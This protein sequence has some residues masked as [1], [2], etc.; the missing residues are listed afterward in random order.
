MPEHQ[1]RY[2]TKKIEL[3][4]A[5]YYLITNEDSKI[6]LH[7]YDYKQENLSLHYKTRRFTRQVIQ[8][9]TFDASSS[10]MQPT[11]ALI[12]T[13]KTGNRIV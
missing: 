12:L 7:E 9:W 5:I 11:I 8:P 4:I 6:T 2:E 10:S 3:V 13:K 1:D